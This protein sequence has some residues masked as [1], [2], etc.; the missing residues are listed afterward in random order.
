[1]E[2]AAHVQ[3][4]PLRTLLVHEEADEQRD[5]ADWQNYGPD[6]VAPSPRHV[7]QDATANFGTSPCCPQEWQIEKG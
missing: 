3:T 2:D 5:E 7:P 4:L 1:M 6:G